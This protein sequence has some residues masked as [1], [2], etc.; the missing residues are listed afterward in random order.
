MYANL[1]SSLA[2]MPATFG[3]VPKAL[4]V[5]TAHWESRAPTI[6]TAQTWFVRT[7]SMRAWVYCSIV[8]AKNQ[9]P[10]MGACERDTSG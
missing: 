2:G 10:N 7:N 4:L 1:A 3:A 6:G 9:L 5:I 8:C